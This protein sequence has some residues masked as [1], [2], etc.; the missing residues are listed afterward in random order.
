MKKL[1]VDNGAREMYHKF[2]SVHEEESDSVEPL[3]QENVYPQLPLVYRVQDRYR[4]VYDLILNPVVDE[5]DPHGGSAEWLLSKIAKYR[6]GCLCGTRESSIY[7]KMEHACP[8]G[9]EF[10]NGLLH[11]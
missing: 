2:Q 6:E 10:V 11:G 8:S 4:A 1:K 7:G 5:G 9:I 3:T